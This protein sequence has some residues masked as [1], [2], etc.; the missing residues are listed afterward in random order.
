MRVKYDM[1]HN[2]TGDKIVELPISKREEIGVSPDSYVIVNGS[3]YAVVR[4]GADIRVDER[5]VNNGEDVVLDK[6]PSAVELSMM[7]ESDSDIRGNVSEL[8]K[9]KLIGE[10]IPLDD[11]FEIVV[12]YAGT[13][14]KIKLN[15]QVAEPDAPVVSVTKDTNIQ[16]TEKIIE[17]QVEK[18]NK[19]S[20]ELASYDD[21]GGLHEETEKFREVAEI[22]FKY[23]S[24]FDNLSVNPPT[25]VLLHGPPGTGKSLLAESLANSLDD[26][27][28][29]MPIESPEIF[30]S[31]Q[32]ESSDKIQ[33]IFEDAKEQ[34]PT[35]IF[36]DE[37]EVIA[38]K[39]GESMASVDDKVVAQ[40]LNSMDGMNASDDVTV[41]AATN[42]PDEIDSALRRGGRF[43]REI[44]IG[45]PDSEEREEIIEL[46]AEDTELSSTV[47][48][49]DI[50]DKTQAFVGADIENLFREASMSAVRRQELQYDG[51]S[52]TPNIQVTEQDIQEALKQVEPS[53]LRELRVQVPDVS[54]DDVGGLED[55]K[56]SFR[57]NIEKPITNSEVYE[58]HGV[59]SASGF[60]LS[61][62]T[63][64]GKTLMAKAVANE[65][66]N[67]FISVKGPELISKYV[68]EAEESVRELF[69]KAR[70][71]APTIVF[72]DEIDAIARSR[73]QSSTASSNN[74]TK[75]VVDQLLT[76]IDGL[77]EQAEQVTV[78]GATNKPDDIDE[79]IQRSGRLGKNIHVGVPD[80]EAR[81]EIF[82]IHLEDKR[83]DDSVDV[84]ELVRLTDGYVGADIE[85]ITKDA[86]LKAV[87]R[88]IESG[89]DEY[90]TQEDLREA[91]ENAESSVQ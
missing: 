54:W 29:Y 30:Q 58:K 17:Q 39:R 6:I 15:P 18:D 37:F 23:P 12:S 13:S 25:G 7:Y 81:E 90:V 78:I 20:S 84:A 21:I 56:Q 26:D 2:K 63:G 31:H 1:I 76:E 32:G 72:F 41:I 71:N 10:Q 11:P 51:S 77:D 45:V 69:S 79:A 14:N 9:S 44:E 74:V 89:T 22:P 43:D 55:V 46:Y 19:A 49:D 68:G 5:L 35:V 85:Q 87:K 36:F 50:V 57:Y 66:D 64:T 48:L 65:T 53:G 40:L 38:G 91:V 62:P 34:S 70:Q 67:N 86:A 82:N 42:K 75:R 27:V 61:G 33:S 83:T 52:P 88:E 24:L 60:L 59:S 80:S 3:E 16:L 4:D 47:Q 28:T 8:C 73:D